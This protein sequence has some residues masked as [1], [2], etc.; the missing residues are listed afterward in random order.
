MPNHKDTTQYLV[1][2]EGDIRTEE[3]RILEEENRKK[4]LER[5][6]EQEE[7]QRIIE[8][9]KQKL[10]DQMLAQVEPIYQEA[11]N[12]YKQR[13]FELAKD[14]FLEAEQIF[15]DYK[16]VK[17]YLTRID[18]DV[19]EE[20][21]RREQQRLRELERQEREEEIARKRAE[22]RLAQLREEEE[23][24]K[25]AEFQEEVAARRK[26]REAWLKILEE[27]EKVRKQKLE[28]Q[29]EYVYQEAIQLYK[30]QQF[31]QAKEDFLEAERIIPDYKSTAKYLA[32][33]D[34][35]I[36][37]EE[38]QRW[39]EQQRIAQQKMREEQIA[40]RAQEEELGR[41]RAI[42]DQNR[43]RNFKEQAAEREKQRKEWERV[44][45][46]NEQ[47]R[48][49]RLKEEAE[50]VY[51]E[52]L[53]LYKEKKW[54]P[55]RNGFIEVQQIIPGYK[56]SE[57]YLTRIDRDSEQEVQRL[58]LAS[59]E[60]AQR[61][62]H[63]EELARKQEEERL[64]KII[65]TD[66]K[67]ELEQ[68]ERQAAAVYQ[69]AQSL[70]KKGDYAR[71]KDKFVEV[72]QILPGY[73]STA[74]YIGRMAEDSVEAKKRYENEQRLA[75][76]RQ[77]RE[78]KIEEKKEEKK[79]SQGERAEQE[80]WAEQLK[81]EALARQKEREEW[82]KINKEI[83]ASNQK[84]LN[85]QAE[86]IY[87]E[88]LRY[89]EAGWFEQAQEAFKEVESTV[90]GYK[91]TAK[92]LEKVDKRIKQEDHLHQESEK[93][94]Q[95][96][97]KKE[98]MLRAKRQ[99][100]A[101]AWKLEIAKENRQ[102][103]VMRQ[104]KLQ[105]VEKSDLTVPEENGNAVVKKAVEERQ[106]ELSQKAEVKYREALSAYK[107]KEFIE[108]KLKFIEVES[109]SPGYKATLKYL[110]GI[111][112]KIAN[113]KRNLENEKIS[114]TKEKSDLGTEEAMVRDRDDLVQQALLEEERNFQK[115]KAKKISEQKRTNKQ[116]PQRHE[117]VKKLKDQELDKKDLRKEL[118][119]QRL[120]VQQKYDKQFQQLYDQ[121]VNL[122]RSGSYEEAKEL[123][124]Q[125]EQMKPGYKKA[126][127][128]LK[129]A[130]VKTQKGLQKEKNNHVARTKEI[131]TRAD[132][133]GDA[134]DALE[135]KL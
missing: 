92:Y 72:Q 23:K 135:Q 119:R 116:E 114:D 111:D 11:L 40:Q 15:P 69:F 109:F 12:Y 49:K 19:Q 24:R 58:K 104:A 53:Q 85:Q 126:A 10:Q 32:R 120:I 133:I 66:Q 51:K 117:T 125:I 63:E 68:K 115:T 70:Y 124:L 35:D 67:K 62:R 107:A 52:A 95:E 64:K 84:R 122:Y 105:P 27:T 46:E 60:S 131:K 29:A 118:K 26:D 6:K 4:I 123:F 33:I 102:Q 42:E 59:E 37:E 20:A 54:E 91:S 34:Q 130:S 78:K 43:L 47:E 57:K 96:Y 28:E 82:E 38:K 22:E 56:G 103:K 41:L 128:Y 99:T 132:I 113:Q 39:T 71:A 86:L 79:L 121:A 77:L 45:K 25:I 18:Q 65:E 36:E 97:L 8:E 89:F 74:L 73:K 100:E 94:I 9:S 112:E 31:K 83:E 98:E 93:R 16:S 44:L 30:R 3:Q 14:R 81:K 5:R 108:A 50:F 80:E 88:A 87:Q 75:I 48:Q 76:Q 13:Q 90:S 134:L 1:R 101:D 55:A 17:N 106:K 61:Q 21:Q 129:K 2:I 7:W 110:R 127:S